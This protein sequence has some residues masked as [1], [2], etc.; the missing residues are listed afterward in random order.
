MKRKNSGVTLIALI[1]TIIVLLILAGV[2]IAMIIG[3]NGILNRAVDAAD[4]SKIEDGKE[5][6]A[7]EVVGSYDN[8][9]NIDMDLLKENLENN[10][11][12]DTSNV[13]SNL[14]T[15]TLT[16]DGLNYYID[17]EG[18]VIYIEGELKTWTENE[19][20][21]ITDG[22][23]TVQVGD[24]INYD[25]I[26]GATDTSYTSNATST[27]W[28]E[29]QVFNLNSYTGGWRV[30]GVENG[31]LQIISE[32]IIG[33][34]SGGYTEGTQSYYY[35]DGVTGLRNSITELDN[36]SE[37]YG[38]GKYAQSARSVNQEDIAKVVGLTPEYWNETEGYGNEITYYWDGDI[39]PY[40]ESIL[41]G[42]GDVSRNH[43]NGFY[44]YDYDTEE[45]NHVEYDPSAT[46]ESKNEITTLT[47][48][49]YGCIGSD[50]LDTN[51]T[52]YNLVFGDGGIDAYWLS[53]RCVHINS[54]DSAFGVYFVGLGFV[55]NY[56]LV[57][58]NGAE[59]GSR[60]GVRPLVS[61]QPNI[62]LI[63][64]GEGTWNISDI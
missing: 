31:Q 54:G 7:L 13:G 56:D 40:Y 41:F 15:G 14:P 51:S 63:P 24:Y 23:V 57:E 53:S 26:T 46:E 9:G 44:W 20:G 55:L 38:Q 18:N 28:S 62:Q 5:R 39:Y 61:L 25:P 29:N 8:S 33:P 2:T 50:L 48:T 6:I 64:A 3:D 43:N 1:I 37:L 21:S 27:G 52:K 60:C 36:I 19:D 49:F 17:S 11:G 16:L 45:W 12:I 34:D 59:H 22:E 10:L 42:S 30:L 35:L 4:K 58:S 32:N 47:S